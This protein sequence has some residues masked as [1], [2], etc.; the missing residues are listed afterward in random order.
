M[1]EG[2]TYGPERWPDDESKMTIKKMWSD[3]YRR[4]KMAR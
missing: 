2:Y 4:A 3:S 1:L